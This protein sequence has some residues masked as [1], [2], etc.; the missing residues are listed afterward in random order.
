VGEFGLEEAARNSFDW[1]DGLV[2]TSSVLKYLGGWNQK[3]KRRIG[4]KD[5]ATGLGARALFVGE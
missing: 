1:Q 5:G 4:E 3:L 2:G